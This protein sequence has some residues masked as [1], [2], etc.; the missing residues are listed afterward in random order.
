MSKVNGESKT[1]SSRFAERS[2]DTTRSPLAMCWPSI[3]T[4]TL[5][6]RVQYATG[7]AQRNTSSTALGRTASSLAIP[8]DLLGIRD[9]RLQPDGQRV[10]G[11]VAAGK[12]EHEEEELEFVCGQAELLAVVTG[13]HRGRERAPDVVGGIAPLLGGEFHRVPED[14]GEELGSSCQ[15]GCA[16]G[17]AFRMRSK[18]SKI[19]GRSCSGMPMMSPMTVIGSAS[20]TSS[21]Q[22]PPP[23]GEQAVDHPRRTGPDAVFELGDRPWVERVGDEFSALVQL[24]R[25]HVMI[26]GYDENMAD[27]LDK[28]AVDRGERLGIAVQPDRMPVFGG[29]PE[30]ALDGVGDARRQARARKSGLVRRSSANSSSGKPLRHKAKSERSTAA[31]VM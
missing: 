23:R 4:S 15:L 25:V 29:H 19:R 18:P 20:A 28:W 30:F 22:S 13:D 14:R 21:I 7:D 9:E 27:R 17:E 6:V 10:L 12:R 8:L 24:R 3:S 11:G 31:A 2:I 16:S 5:A 26:V 1:S